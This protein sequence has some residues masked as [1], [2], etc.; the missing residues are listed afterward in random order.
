LALGSIDHAL[1]LGNFDLR[2]DNYP[3]KTLPKLTPRC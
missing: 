3:L 2:H 1:N